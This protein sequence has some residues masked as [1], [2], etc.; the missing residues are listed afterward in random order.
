MKR[1]IWMCLEC[2]RYCYKVQY[3]N[4]ETAWMSHMHPGDASTHCDADERSKGRRCQRCHTLCY[5]NGVRFVHPKTGYAVD[6]C[7]DR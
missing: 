2:G 7:F 6:K 3:P 5:F 4:G 1:R